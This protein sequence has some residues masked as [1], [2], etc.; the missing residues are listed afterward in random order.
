MDSPPQPQATTPSLIS[1]IAHLALWCLLE[2]KSNTFK[3][4]IPDNADIGDLKTTIKLEKP[5]ELERVLMLINS[6]FGRWGSCTMTHLRFKLTS[7]LAAQRTS[8]RQA[9]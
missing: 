4:E 7:K 6:F 3:V 2:G 1:G 8:P 9:R 5:I